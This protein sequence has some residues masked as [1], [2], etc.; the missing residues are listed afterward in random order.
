MKF[1][2]HCGT[3]VTTP[4]PTQLPS[5]QQSIKPSHTIR[6]ILVAVGL[7]FI[8]GIFAIALSVPRPPAALVAP[9]T[10][11][12]QEG[13][14]VTMGQQFI[15]RFGTDSVPKVVFDSA[16]F[17]ST[18]KYHKAGSGY[19]LLVLQLTAQNIGNKEVNAFSWLDKWEVT[20]DK[21]YVYEPKTKPSLD[22][23]PE[24]KKTEYAVFEI[25]QDT[26]PIEVK[27]HKLLSLSPN[28][29]LNLKGASITT[30]T[31]PS[32]TETTTTPS[33]LQQ[34]ESVIRMGQPL[35]L[36][37]GSENIPVEITFTSAW[38]ATKHSYYTAD[39][40]YKL[41]VLG[42]RA[43]NIGMKET[44]FL[45]GIKWEI[46]VD[47][48]YLYREKTCNLT[49]RSLRPEETKIGYVLF[50]ILATTNPMEIRYYGSLI[51]K[52]PTLVLDIRGESIPTKTAIVNENASTSLCSWAIGHS[53]TIRNASLDP[54]KDL[55][56]AIAS[57]NR[58]WFQ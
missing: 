45:C 49:C 42:I 53:S 35:V 5:S 54:L 18:H 44:S 22:I 15:L 28:V 55:Q 27:Y 2:M 10:S 26:I 37:S 32:K 16:W 9:T 56:L 47:K 38:F 17:T 3:S 12:M 21:G 57:T 20:V 13:G 36:K 34:Q 8:I 11:Q 19:K 43:R 6:N 51:E 24:E 33:P 1:C 58:G 46:T 40:G 50:E 25:L 48:G 7:V 39:K 29:I 30:A 31:P 4:L 52:G 41:L 23:R 14:T